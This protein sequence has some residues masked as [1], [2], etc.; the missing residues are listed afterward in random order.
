MLDYFLR[1]YTPL[2]TAFYFALCTDAV[3][4]TADTN[5]LGELAEIAVGNGYDAGGRIRLANADNF[6]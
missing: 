4:P 5:T 3:A 2:P 1:R 6:I